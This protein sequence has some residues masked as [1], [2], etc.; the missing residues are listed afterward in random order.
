MSSVWATIDD[1]GRAT[2]WLRRKISLWLLCLSHLVDLGRWFH[3]D[4]SSFWQVT[5]ITNINIC[6]G[7]CL[8]KSIIFDITSSWFHYLILLLALCLPLFLE[9]FLQAT[10]EVR[11]NFVG[12]CLKLLN[13][14]H[15]L[16]VLFFLISYSALLPEM[17]QV[18]E[19]EVRPKENALLEGATSK[20]KST[21][22]VWDRDC[23]VIKSEFK[24]SL[25]L[26]GLEWIWASEESWE[27]SQFL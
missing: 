4:F 18:C 12:K 6:M 22:R 1:T 13:S 9:K 8:W 3:L 10:Q 7:K 27:P 23:S 17:R 15:L 25:R 19:L 5:F 26:W 20:C 21:V 16:C 2:E 14:T 24:S 11:Q